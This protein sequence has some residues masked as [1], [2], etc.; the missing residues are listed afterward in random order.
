[1]KLAKR[2]LAVALTV[3]PV[4]MVALTVTGTAAAGNGKV[5]IL[6]PSVVDG[7]SSHEAQ[8]AIAAG[9]GVDLV[10]GETWSEMSTAEFAAYDAIVVSD[11]VCG[12]DQSAAVANAATWSAAVTGNVIAL[13]L[14][15]GYHATYG[16][17]QA[18]ATA[19]FNAGIRYAL[20][21]G[22]HTGAYL[23][24]GCQSSADLLSQLSP[25]GAFG[26][27]DISGDAVQVVAAPAPTELAGLTD[28]DL[29]N[30]YSSYHAV[31]TSYPSD[32]EAFATGGTD[33]A[34][35]VTRGGS[36]GSVSRGGYCTVA[37]NTS[38]STGAALAPGSFVDLVNGQADSDPNFKGALPAN[39]LEGVGIT[40]D[41]RPG[42][43]KTGQK[44]GYGGLGDPGSY[45]YYKKG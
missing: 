4:L 27:G 11:G 38:P 26:F 44:V 25:H 28:T 40:C 45:D 10:D 16:S 3:L 29:S 18:G 17:N 2:W 41:T 33:G 22:G 9:R 43:T 42:Y 8:A 21:D 7:A 12:G 19:L 37:G 1:M 20:G 5:L 39:Y 15:P 35:I 24:I 14:D 36:A 23:S 30:W 31:F 6:D 32:F 13:G 34:V